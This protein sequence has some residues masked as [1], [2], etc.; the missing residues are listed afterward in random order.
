MN[1][2]SL[3]ENGRSKTIEQFATGKRSTKKKLSITQKH[4]RK[5]YEKIEAFRL[6]AFEAIELSADT[7][8][9]PDHEA[10]AES[11]G[12]ARREKRTQWS[13]RLQAAPDGE[14]APEGCIQHPGRANAELRPEGDP[15]AR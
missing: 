11:A 15:D 6:E 2:N 1:R 3:S 4:I 14:T 5:D 9:I 10:E 8:S 7:Q 12:P 13:F